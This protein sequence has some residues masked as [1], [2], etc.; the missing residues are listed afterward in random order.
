MAL[1][2]LCRI[3]HHF[4]GVRALGG[5][6]LAIE[7]G[8]VHGL[9]GPN[10]AGKTTVF[11]VITGIVRADAGEVLFKGRPVGGLS[12]VARARLGIQRLFQTTQLFATLTVDQHFQLVGGC[13]RGWS[14]RLELNPWLG[15][16]PPELS[17]GIARQVELALVLSRPCDLLLLDEPAA[18]LTGEERQ[19]MA[20]L[21]RTVRDSGT[22]IIL[23]EHDLD[24]TLK[25]VDRMTVLDRGR[26]I[27]DG[28]PLAVAGDPAVRA[29]YL[30]E[31]PD[32][33][34]GL[35]EESR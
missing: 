31:E 11:N 35:R 34:K 26:V 1:L 16:R 20:S 33:L 12:S 25:L 3:S 23:V 15:L 7:P 24:W 22:T 4:S 17:F 29:A 8:S 32:G 6:D 21:L 18:G 2:E 5:V 27:A 13:D 14:Q 30:G 10:G 19:R 28:R 9:I